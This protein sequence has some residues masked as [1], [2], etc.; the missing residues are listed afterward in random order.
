MK[1]LQISEIIR[2]YAQGI[3]YLAALIAAWLALLAYR[4]N[5]R[6]ERARWL[7][8]L[9]EKY[10]E[11]SSLKK[12]RDVLDRESSDSDVVKSIVQKE[13]AE[14]TDYLNFFEYMAYLVKQKQLESSDVMALFRFY[15]NDLKKHGIV[16]EY[17]RKPSSGFE[18]LKDWLAKGL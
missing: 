3:S 16:S 15:L 9:Y 1:A 17:V 14:F 7:A 8:Q 10:Y 13:S 18:N 12:V 6:L 5:I 11:Q 2:N 4:K